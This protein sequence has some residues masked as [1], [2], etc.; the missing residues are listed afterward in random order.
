MGPEPVIFAGVMPASATPGVIIPGQF[1]PMMRVPPT[2]LRVR[3]QFGGVLEPEYL[4]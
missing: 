2:F 1:G 3:P 4:R